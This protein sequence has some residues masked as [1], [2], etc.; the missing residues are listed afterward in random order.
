M[1]TGN[2]TISLGVGFWEFVLKIVIYYLHERV[3][4]FLDFG[5]RK[6]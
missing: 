3:W 1:A 6:K 4:N 5:R 2:L